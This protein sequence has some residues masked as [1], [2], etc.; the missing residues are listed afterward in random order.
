MKLIE[1][2]PNALPGI[3]VETYTRSISLTDA[4]KQYAYFGFDR[5]LLDPSP[6]F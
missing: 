6:G 1:K 3:Q 5:Q 4:I 2:E